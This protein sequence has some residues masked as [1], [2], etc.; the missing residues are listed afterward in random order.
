MKTCYIFGACE[1][2]PEKFQ[3][4]SNDLIIAADGGM[5]ILNKLKVSPCILLG[6]FDSLSEK[7][8]FDGEIVRYP[9]KKDDTDTML[10]I[11]T[12]LERGY[13]KFVLYGCTG[14]RLDHTIANI[15]ALN[16]I[17]ENNALGYLCGD[18]FTVTVIKEGKIE[19]DPKAKGNISVFSLS[20][21]SEVTIEGL[22]YNIKDT[23]ISNS[24]PLGVSNEFIGQKSQITVNR[25][26]VII[27]WSNG[28]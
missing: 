16:Y 7:I 20:N 19:F 2:M 13:K 14:G 18:D 3:P 9:A 27:Y 10:A 22:L 17:A 15:Q 24:N 23:K 8:C 5:N 6:D 25:G 11:K 28:L 4:N 1:G 26:T 12:G 21:T